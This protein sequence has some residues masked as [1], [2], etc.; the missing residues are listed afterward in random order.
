[1]QK[2]SSHLTPTNQIIECHPESTYLNAEVLCIQA[3]TTQSLSTY[4][5]DVPTLVWTGKR[6]EGAFIAQLQNG[7]WWTVFIEMKSSDYPSRIENG[8]NKDSAR[9]SAEKKFIAAIDH[10][11]KSGISTSDGQI[12][13]QDWANH[14]DPILNLPDRN[15]EVGFVIVFARSGS[16]SPNPFRVNHPTPLQK[17]VPARIVFGSYT[18]IGFVAECGKAGIG[19]SIDADQ[20]IP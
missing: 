16:R 10:F 6:P 11:C 1:M 15:H 20:L 17:A 4:T 5:I 7:D 14:S 13:H 8:K 3:G 9:E 12:H 18:N 19:M 2:L